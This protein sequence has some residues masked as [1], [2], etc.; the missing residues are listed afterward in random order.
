MALFRVETKQ[1]NSEIWNGDCETIDAMSALE[2]AAIMADYLNN[3]LLQY[4]GFNGNDRADKITEIMNTMQF[5]V[6]NPRG[7]GW[8]GKVFNYSDLK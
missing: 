1:V 4:S 6:S 5:R 3:C 8:F 2:A 7:Y